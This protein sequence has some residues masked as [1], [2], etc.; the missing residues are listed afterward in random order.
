MEKSTSKAAAATLAILAT[1][2]FSACGASDT[3]ADSANAESKTVEVFAAASL[4][5]VGSELEQAYESSHEGADITFNYAGSSKLVQQMEQGATPDLL[6]TADTK[7]MDGALD[8]IADLDGVTPDTIATNALVLATA[9]GNPA[10]IES[11]S[12]LSG[13]TTVAICAVEVPCG[14][15]AHQELENQ[16]ITLANASEEQN[17]SDVSTKVATGA[18]DAGFIYSTDATVIK[19]E[20]DI[21][22]IDLPDLERNQYPLALTK[23]GESN[24]T[25]GDFATWLTSDDAQEILA[26]YGF[27]AAS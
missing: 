20:Q 19:K 21:T 12:E 3:S 22:V 27:G 24:D 4:N 25:A 7:T 11:V 23:T 14:N 1:S 5:A 8:S 26:S 10:G 6:L 2:L 16:G 18:V 13:D 9:E 17:V 15:L